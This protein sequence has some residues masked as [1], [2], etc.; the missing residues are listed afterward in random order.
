M[1]Y[2]ESKTIIKNKAKTNGIAICRMPF[3]KRQFI[4]MLLITFGE[5]LN[6]ISYHC[7]SNFKVE[8]NVI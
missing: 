7:E 6:L 2:L 5:I 1:T 3:P 8:E 4:N